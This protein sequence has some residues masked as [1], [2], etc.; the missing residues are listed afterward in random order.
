MASLLS[1]NSVI[2]PKTELSFEEQLEH[3]VSAHARTSGLTMEQAWT[4]AFG[5]IRP[6][7]PTI[8]HLEVKSDDSKH[9]E[10]SDDSKW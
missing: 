4:E 2:H 5:L 9:W 10:N 1:G 7:V 8:D 3:L 6:H